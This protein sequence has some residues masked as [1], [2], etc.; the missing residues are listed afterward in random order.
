MPVIMGKRGPDGILLKMLTT[1]FKRR[2][3]NLRLLILVQL[4]MYGMYW[5]LIEEQRMFYLYLNNVR[6]KDVQSFSL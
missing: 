4:A 6:M 2:E 5:F 1:V 3:K